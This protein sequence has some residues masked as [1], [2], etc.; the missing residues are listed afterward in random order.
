MQSK[1]CVNMT[2]ARQ[3]KLF[4]T[5]GSLVAS[6]LALP[7]SQKP[8]GNDEDDDT[9]LPV[10]VWHGTSRPRDARFTPQ[11]HTHETT[12]LLCTAPLN[13]GA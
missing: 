7:W 11:I 3:A 8:L 2:F 6:T 5:F 1:S 13:G 10:V 4:L 12:T 9:P